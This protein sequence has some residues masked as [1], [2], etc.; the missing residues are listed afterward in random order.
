[1]RLHDVITSSFINCY[2]KTMMFFYIIAVCFINYSLSTS[3]TLNFTPPTDTS[4]RRLTVDSLTGRVYVGAVNHLYQLDSNL[5]LVVDVTTGPV[6]DNKDCMYFS[7]G[8]LNCPG[9]STSWNDDYNQVTVFT[10][11]VFR[12]VILYYATCQN[13]QQN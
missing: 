4:L 3:S 7:A 9:L 11:Y 2:Y 13:T 1:M 6:Q 12:L 10:D 5:S 8:Q